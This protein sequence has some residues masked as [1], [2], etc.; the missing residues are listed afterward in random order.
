MVIREKR[1]LLISPEPWDHIF[2]SK[3][4][5]AVCLATAGNQVYFLDPPDEKLG[6]L[7]TDFPNLYVVRCQKFLRGLRFFPRWVQ[8][9]AMRTKFMQIQSM[10]NTR[11]DVVWSFDNSIFYDFAFLPSNILKIS[12]IVDL[13]QNFQMKTAASTA[14]Y[15]FCTTERIKQRMLKFNAKVTKINHGWNL[16]PRIDFSPPLPSERPMAL[17]A[18][19]LTMPFIDWVIL[20]DIVL[21]HPEVDFLFI[22]PNTSPSRES[23]LMAVAKTTVFKSPNVRALGKVAS[24]SLQHYYLQADLL[25]IAYQEEFHQDQANPHKMMEYLGS[26]K[27]VVCTFTEEFAELSDRGLL[28]MSDRNADFCRVFDAALEDLPFWNSNALI[29]TRRNFAL[30]NTYDKQLRRI[31]SVI[32]QEEESETSGG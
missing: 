7:Q 6:I 20:R 1:I 23:L 25:L 5:Y 31:Q 8:R 11:F 14:S 2:V 12:H 19:N 13:N 9:V 32:G 3:H 29:Q 4:H 15:C 22:G 24:D 30:E 28:L 26:G 16:P 27:M 17:Y 21:A 18:G 10:C